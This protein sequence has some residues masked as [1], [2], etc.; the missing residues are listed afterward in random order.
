MAL[1]W[2]TVFLPT[3]PAPSPSLYQMAA[4]LT[5]QG[6]GKTW[7]LQWIWGRV[8]VSLQS[9]IITII[10]LYCTLPI[11]FKFL[12]YCRCFIA[13]AFS[14]DKNKSTTRRTT[15]LQDFL[16]NPLFPWHVLGMCWG[17]SCVVL[18]VILMRNLALTKAFLHLWW[19]WWLNP[20]WDFL[21][22]YLKLMHCPE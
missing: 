3:T 10:Q 19:M 15:L 17:G 12:N 11:W 18:F 22:W 7:P 13:K 1:T 5:T 8:R 9:I 4:G 2:P 6:E 14:T 21:P 20:W 16:F